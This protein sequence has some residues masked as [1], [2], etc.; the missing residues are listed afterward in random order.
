VPGEEAPREAAADDPYA[1]RHRAGDPTIAPEY[2]TFGRIKSYTDLNT[3][4]TRRYSYADSPDPAAP[5]AA[6]DHAVI[7]VG[8]YLYP[9]LDPDYPDYPTLNAVTVTDQDGRALWRLTLRFSPFGPFDAYR[10]ERIEPAAG[11][12]A[13]PDDHPDLRE[14]TG[15]HADGDDP[16]GRDAQLRAAGGEP[17]AGAPPPPGRGAVPRSHTDGHR[18]GGKHPTFHQH[19]HTHSYAVSSNWDVHYHQPHRHRHGT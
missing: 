6:A 13:G 12:R 3:G 2:D 9:G 16:P 17:G 8:A 19:P 11:G 18:H 15:G 14:P 5:G 7:A 10:V 4:N 1:R